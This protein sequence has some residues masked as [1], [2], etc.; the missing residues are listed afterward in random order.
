MALDNL[1]DH[2]TSS[3]VCKIV[4]DYSGPI[5]TEAEKQ[6]FKDKK[7]DAKYA[8]RKSQS[9]YEE[10][11]AAEQ[12]LSEEREQKILEFKDNREN[13]I[14]ELAVLI[15]L[16]DQTLF[17]YNVLRQLG[18]MLEIN[19]KSADEF[20]HDLDGMFQKILELNGKIG[21]SEKALETFGFR[22][23][24]GWKTDIANCFAY[25]YV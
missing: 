6:A 20:A 8:E 15:P 5:Y 16:K 13:A 3:D 18:P 25:K 22:P 12:K 14:K 24:S 23:Y 21:N 11:I 7:F 9:D 4:L 1:Q 2:M 10:R 19:G 17:S